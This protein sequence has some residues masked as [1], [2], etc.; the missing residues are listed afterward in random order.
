MNNTHQQAL[1]DPSD[2][3]HSSSASLFCSRRLPSSTV[4]SYLLRCHGLLRCHVINTLIN[5]HQN[6]IDTT[7]QQRD[8]TI[9]TNK[10][11][12]GIGTPIQAFAFQHI[13]GSSNLCQGLWVIQV[14][15]WRILLRRRIN[16]LVIGKPGNR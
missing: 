16:D 11:A 3:Q 14:T 8:S 2:S 9:P 7:Q 5:C 13:T 4:T 10:W 1:L 6:K 15:L 12:T